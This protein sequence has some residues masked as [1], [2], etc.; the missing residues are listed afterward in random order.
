MRFRHSSVFKVLFYHLWN[1]LNS[2]AQNL[3]FYTLPAY[4]LLYDS[5]FEILILTDSEHSVLEWTIHIATPNFLDIDVKFWTQWWF[6]FSIWSLPFVPPCLLGTYPFPA[7]RASCH[8]QLLVDPF[9][10]NVPRI[11]S[12]NLMIIYIVSSS[13][14]MSRIF[15]L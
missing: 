8:L 13:C 6:R 1:N 2:L 12:K 11:I 9:M 14:S 15:C 3:V 10:F 4:F 7:S 5:S